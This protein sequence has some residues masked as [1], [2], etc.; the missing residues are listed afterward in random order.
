M[1]AWNLGPVVLP[2]VKHVLEMYTPLNLPF[3]YSK[4]GVL[5]GIPI[6]F[7]LLQNID[8][9]YLLEMPRRGGSN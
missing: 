6:F 3:I 9:G 7:I 4:T 8:C 1:E 5:R 2:S